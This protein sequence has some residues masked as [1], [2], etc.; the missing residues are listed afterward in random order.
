MTQK[1]YWKTP[2][3]TKFTAK[4]EAIKEKGIVLDKTLFYP[5]SGNQV[6]DRGYLQ[7]ND[8][9]I[10]VNHVIKEGDNILHQ[11]SAELKRKIN[12][13]D[14]VRGEID[15]EYR[16]GVMKAH[17]SQHIFSAVIK[18]KY[19]I[20][21]ERANLS[22]E[23]VFLKISQKIDYEQLRRILIEV[24]KI[25]TTQNFRLNAKI[26]PR[27]EAVKFSEIIRSS[28]PDDSHIRLLEIQELDLVCCGGTHVKNTTEI[29]AICIY[30]FKKGKE[31]RYVVGNKALELSTNF[32][33]DLITLANDINSP[34]VKL[35]WLLKK[36][37]KL[38][39]SIQEQNK[40]LSI[41]LLELSSKLPLKTIGK[42]QLF[43]IDF[44]IDIKILNKSLGNFPHNSL[45]IIKFESNKIRI[46]SPN[47]IIDSN[48]L[49][50][51]LIKKY[52]GKGGGNPKSSQGF[53]KKMPENILIEIESF[54]RRN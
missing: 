9:K 41:K 3:E 10:E 37:L 27:K 34:V 21:T 19:D 18:S 5:E 12:I 45:I 38:I 11:I 8:L 32:S 23:D 30:E 36:H 14:Q 2:Y 40:N 53:L 43:Y 13:G 24:N 39:E 25:C 44:D 33:L 16:Y 47:E 17:S 52:G 1:L 29:G 26:I 6:S 28:I 4:I 31:I 48:Q 15:W 50:N 46:L 49:L 22:F 35:R 42:I 7:V 54:L 20:D 51:N